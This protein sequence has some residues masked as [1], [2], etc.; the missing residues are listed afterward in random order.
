MKLKEMLINILSNA[1]KFTEAPGSI[2]MT[3]EKT[4]EYDNQSTLRF[5]IKDTGIGMD[6][7][8]IPKIFDAF[9]QKNSGFRTKYGSSGLGM[10]ITKRIVDMMNGSINV[11]SEK[12]VGTEFTVSVTLRNGEH[13]ETDRIREINK[14]AFYIL[15]VDDDPIE[16]EHAGVVLEDVGIRADYC[17]SGQEALRRMEIQHGKADAYNLVLLDWNMPGMNGLETSTEILKLY[18][19]ECTVVAMTA[20]SWE[21]IQNEAESVG[22]ENYVS[23]P[24]FAGNII[25]S[26][27]RI[28]RRSR[29]D[30]FKE[31]KQANLNGRRI[32]LAEDVE[33]NAEILMDSLEIENIQVD[34][35][36]NG[37]AAVEM[38]EKST[39]GIYAAILMDVRMP[40]MDG[41][42]AAR[43]IRSMRRADA[44][45]I[46]IIALTANAFDED[47]QLSMQAGMNAHLIKPV[48][49]D[50]LLRVLGGLVYEN[51][52]KAYE[53]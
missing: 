31:K 23:K 4:A 40:V 49:A 3:I 36:P 17:T 30:I 47:V 26:I 27:E 20:Y 42:E 6:K 48:E 10:A 28:A 14:E 46:P 50:Q 2:T 32:L 29:M 38:F 15:V 21:D 8:Y 37:K 12:G 24:L 19:N 7:D 53:Y 51:E 13:K 34:H 33:L 43:T 35:A 39:A 41:L 45:T 44:K 11:Q 9:S 52:N 16:A 22:V 5:S 1:I 18:G 25:E